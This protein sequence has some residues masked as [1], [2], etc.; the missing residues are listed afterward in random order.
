MKVEQ[1]PG[2]SVIQPDHPELSYGTLALMQTLGTSSPAF[3]DG[4][5]RQIANAVSPG[6]EASEA[7]INFVLGL[8]CGIEPRDDAEAMLASQMAAVHSEELGP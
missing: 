5:L 7:D 2:G 3:M 6:R 8:V 4:Q 1:K